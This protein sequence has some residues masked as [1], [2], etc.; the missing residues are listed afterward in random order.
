M[1]RLV[2]GTQLHQPRSA[3]G[4]RIGDG[5]RTERIGAQALQ[6]VGLHD[7]HVF[8]GRSME[9]QLGPAFLHDSLNPARIPDIGHDNAPCQRG[10]DFRDPDIAL[11]DGELAAV[12]QQQLCWHE[13]SELAGQLTADASPGSRHH[14]PPARNEPL[15]PFTVQLHLLTIQKIFDHDRL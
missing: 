12:Q 5:L 3:G 13:S 7:R 9:Y 11:P 4:G 14:H 8:E 10:G 2:R 15:Q 1:D 6:P